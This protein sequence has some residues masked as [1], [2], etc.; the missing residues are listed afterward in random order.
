MILMSPPDDGAR[1][2]GLHEVPHSNRD[3]PPRQDRRVFVVDTAYLTPQLQS[4]HPSLPTWQLFH[5][6]P[7]RPVHLL[8][9]RRRPSVR[10]LP[11]NR[12][13]GGA[14]ASPLKRWRCLA[15]ASCSPGCYLPRGWAWLPQGET[16]RGS[17]IKRSVCRPHVSGTC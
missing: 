4:A 10:I 3:A 5:G 15:S 8:K 9:G 14:G 12:P 16:R 17:R 2:H 1:L 13:N 6:R 7:T 11:G